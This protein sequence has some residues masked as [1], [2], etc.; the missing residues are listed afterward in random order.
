MTE[1]SNYSIEE[2]L[3]LKNEI[4]NRIFNYKDGYLYVCI[5]RSYGRN[6]ED[7]SIHNIHTLQELLLQYD[8]QDGIV[9]VY[10]TNP[11]LS[12]IYNYGS[13]MFIESREDYDKWSKY[14]TNKNLI[15]NIEASLD[16]WDKRDNVSFSQRPLF[17]PS[18]TRE[19]LEEY[20]RELETCD[21]SF[22][23]PRPYVKDHD[24]DEE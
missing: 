2:L 9:D 11:D 5:I 19:E 14:Q 6:W 7:K 18:F 4:D 8:G 12:K 24:Q 10:S 16:A 13:L 23:P 1:L 17:P 22:V 3:L 15:H 20:K 21:M